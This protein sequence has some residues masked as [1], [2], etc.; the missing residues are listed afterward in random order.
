MYLPP[1]GEREPV[2]GRRPY[3]IGPEA[4]PGRPLPVDEVRKPF[5]LLGVG[6]FVGEGVGEEVEVERLP[7][8][9]GV[10]QQHAVRRMQRV[11]A[12]REQRLDR[13]RK[14]VFAARRDGELAD[15]EGVAGRALG[16]GRELG[17]GE[18]SVSGGCE[19]E[20]AGVVGGERLQLEHGRG[21]AECRA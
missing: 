15:E 10:A 4:E 13:F 12:V 17:L 9:G 5:P 16:E 6:A 2:V 20:A 11:D 8:H 3:E 19:R 1:P 14:R 21:L 7:Y 18:G